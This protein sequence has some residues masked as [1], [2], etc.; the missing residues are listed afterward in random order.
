LVHDAARI[1]DNQ[2]I[3][4][5]Y[6][7]ES[8]A[9]R[10]DR[11]TVSNSFLNR[12]FGG[13]TIPH[14]RDTG[15]LDPARHE[16][17]AIRDRLGLADKQ[18][19]VFMGT[20]RAHKGVTELI[21]AVD[22]LGSPGVVLLLVGVD[23]ATQRS[24]PDHPFIRVV[25]PQPFESIPEFLA[26]ADLVVLNQRPGAAGGGQLPA[27]VF[28]AMSM[29]K[30]IIATDVSDL[31]KVLNGCGS[32]VSGTSTAELASAIDDVLS[33]PEAALQMGRRARDR[34]VEYYSLDSVRPKLR[35]LVESTLAKFDSTV[36]A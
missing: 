15:L 30:P 10:A 34:C 25:G 18:V 6:L 32:V 16:R 35:A 31:S 9:H 20:I 17:N 4:W 12:K 5:T 21:E 22:R 19:I 29:A 13:T 26:A 1:W 27:K 23:E 33:D 11:I 28:D 2:N 3:V 14:F 7:M 8:F 36:A 24:L